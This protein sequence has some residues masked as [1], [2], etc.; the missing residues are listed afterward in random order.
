MLFPRS[1]ASAVRSWRRSPRKLTKRLRTRS[2]G[3]PASSDATSGS[4]AAKTTASPAAKGSEAWLAQLKKPDFPVRFAPAVVKYLKYYK[5]LSDASDSTK[6][7]AAIDLAFATVQPPSGKVLTV[8]L[9]GAKDMQLKC[10]T[11]VL[12][13]KWFESI[14]TLQEQAKS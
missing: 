14:Q 11:D 10:A 5:N 12:A 4:A 7:L 1:K 8:Q 3:L 9:A 13:K 6:C 2:N